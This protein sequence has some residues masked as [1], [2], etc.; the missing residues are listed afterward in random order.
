MT[1]LESELLLLSVAAA[2]ASVAFLAIELVQRW[3]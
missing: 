3:A 1:R 2:I